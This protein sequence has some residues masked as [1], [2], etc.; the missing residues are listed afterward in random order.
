M[1]IARYIIEGFLILTIS[2]YF[3][4]KF[5]IL[6]KKRS[7]IKRQF[8][9]RYLENEKEREIIY[10]HHYNMMKLYKSKLVDKIK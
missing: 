9:K 6:L 1:E 10:K 2:P 3:V 4:L 8:L 7:I 5:I